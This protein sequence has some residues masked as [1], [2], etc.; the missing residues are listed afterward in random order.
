VQRFLARQ[1]IFNS[2]RVVYGYELLFRS[3]PENRYDALQADVA[4]ASTVDSILLYGIERLTPGCRA[5]LNCTRDFLIRDFATML[6]PDRVVLEILETVPMDD[7]VHGACRRLKQAGYLLALDDFQ[8]RPDWKP[9]V[10]MADFIKVDL[11]ATSPADQLR[12]A[13]TYLPMNIRLVAEKVETYNDFHRTLRWGYAYFQGYFFSRPEMLAGNDI[14]PNQMNHLLALQAVNRQPMDVG[15][16]GARIK[17]EA[18]LSFRLLRYLNSPAFPL[19]GEV[20]SIPHALALLGERG[21][22]KWVSLI[23]VTCMASRKPPE[24]AALPLIRAQ[25]CELLAPYARQPDS[26]NDLFLLGLLSAMDAILDMRMPDVLKEI[27][28]HQ[29]IRDALMGKANKLREIFE[30]ALNYERG[31]WDEIGPSATRLGIQEDMIPGLYVAAVEWARRILYPH[32]APVLPQ[33]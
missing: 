11:L 9:L 26:A 8:E 12:L 24:L 10:A 5:F 23:A 33:V 13:R 22:R 21:A 2:A 16:V 20:R 14:P 28:V 17:A 31:R 7:E 27:T 19:L 30:F 32:E 6:P 25:F 29:E 4:S 1:P 3:G 18:S 15:E